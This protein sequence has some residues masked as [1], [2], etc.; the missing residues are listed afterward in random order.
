MTP[1]DLDRS[2]TVASRL[3]L[4]VLLCA[5]ALGIVGMHGLGSGPEA[6]VHLGH[7]AGHPHTLAPDLTQ[8]VAASSGVV[9]GDETSPAHD[10]GVLALCLMVLTSGLVLGIWLFA[11]ARAGGWRLPRWSAQATAA[12][13]VAVL[14]TPFRR[15]PAVL[16]I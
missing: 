4:V 9:V 5:I 7:P 1:V 14:P 3:P 13:D 10:S 16:R 2:G 8:G 15:Q 12:V 6:P 11:A